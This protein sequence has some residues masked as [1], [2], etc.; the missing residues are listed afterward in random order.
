LRIGVRTVNR[1]LENIRDKAGRRR[2]SELMRYAREE[3][4]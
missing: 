3:Y 4:G 2:R 1:H